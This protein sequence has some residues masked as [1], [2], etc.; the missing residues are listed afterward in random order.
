MTKRRRKWNTH[1]ESLGKSPE[2]YII[3]SYV[4]Q[5]D[6][7]ISRTLT[8]HGFT[9]T[10]TAV[11]QKRSVGLRLAKTRAGDPTYIRSSNLPFVAGGMQIEE[12][13][14]L[15]L[16]DVE[17][18]FHNAQWINKCV[19]LALLWGI[20]AVIFNGDLL[21]FE[22]LSP[23]GRDWDGHGNKATE[24]MSP[25]A[26]ETL[27]KFADDKSA[28]TQNAAAEFINDQGVRG[29]AIENPTDEIRR[30]NKL[31]TDF[32]K[33]FRRAYW[34]MGNHEYRWVRG[35]EY[36]N[37]PVDLMHVLGNHDWI[38]M[39][40]GHRWAE[41]YS[42]GVKW[43]I[44]HPGATSVTA[45]MVA[46]ELCSIHLSNVV[47]SHNHLW[48]EMQDRSGKFQAVEIGC[49]VDFDR[50]RY[51][52]FT[53]TRRPKMTPGAAI[54]DNGKCTLLHPTW[55]NWERLGWKEEDFSDG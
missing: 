43:R 19:H 31:I 9:T 32:S 41:L 22:S 34:I 30:A 2:Q 45:A 23:F 48:G 33:V 53:D 20:E 25:E 28:R 54:I 35:I 17:A 26:A 36:A 51:A 8:Q 49:C 37:H 14:V 16:G 4:H 24:G 12:D 6:S 10:K 42:G 52:S 7:Q 11:T 13:K 5:T 46:R 47:Q 18:P 29:Q 27:Q 50:L 21:H 39:S 15:I 44:T 55:T 1:I 3:D 40:H 38:T